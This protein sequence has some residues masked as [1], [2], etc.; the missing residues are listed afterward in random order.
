MNFRFPDK[1]TTTTPEFF[2]RP[3]E[4]LAKWI[5]QR[6]YDG[7]RMPTFIEGANTVRCFSHA[8]RPI[9]QAYRGKLPTDLEDR[10]IELGLP[11]GT[12]IDCE[13][14]GP[15]G[16]HKHAVYVFDMLA[17]NGNWLMDEPFEVRWQRV[18]DL[19]APRVYQDGLIFIADTIYPSKSDKINPILAEFNTLKS[20]WV[21]QGGGM[22]YMYEGLVVK[23]RSGRLILN[24]RERAR[25]PDMY[26][27]KFRDIGDTRY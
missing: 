25:S 8:N 10:F 2:D 4:E 1:P 21:E 18:L 20:E 16:S 23:R 26:K 22:D 12:V 6:K 27:V 24:R 7:W 19:I 3:A 13:L 11:D 9:A 5:S 14:M 17:L 15:R